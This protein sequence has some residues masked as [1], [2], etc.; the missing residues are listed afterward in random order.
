M[1]RQVSRSHAQRLTMGT[2]AD[3]LQYTLNYG[4]QVGEEDD[5]F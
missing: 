2:T 4:C 1:V 5:S 3:I